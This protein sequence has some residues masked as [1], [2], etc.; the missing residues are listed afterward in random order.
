MPTGEWRSL[1]ASDIG[2]IARNIRITTEDWSKVPDGQKE[3]IWLDVKKKWNI[4]DEERRKT[5]LTYV[6]DRFKGFKTY[7]TS[8]FVYHTK[9]SRRTEAVDPLTIYPQITKEDWDEFVKQR[10]DPE[11]RKKSD[12]ARASQKNNIHPHYMGRAGYT[13]KK[14]QWFKEELEK[15]S[16]ENPD[17]DPIQT[18]ESVE[19]R[20]SDRAY[21]WIK[22]HTPATRSLPPQT[23]KLIDD[24]KHWSEMVEKGE[25]VPSRLED[26]LVKATGKPD[27]PGRTRGVGSH[28]GLQTYFGKPTG[29]GSRGK[30]YS[31]DDMMMFKEEVK[32]ETMAE[33]K[34][35]MQQQFLELMKVCG[36]KL[37]P[38]F[39]LNMTDSPISS[40]HLH[41]SSCH[42]IELRDPFSEL[43]GPTPCRLGVLDF[44]DVV[45]VAEGMAW[46]WTENQTIHN[47][48]LS[49]Q[50][51]RV[52]IDKILEITAPLPIPWGGFK[53]VGEVG[54]SFAQW[55]KSLVMMGL[56]EALSSDKFKSKET[57]ES[58]N[59]A[60][61]VVRKTP[62]KTSKAKSS[63]KFKSKDKESGNKAKS[64]DKFKSKDKEP[65]NKVN[66]EDQEDQEHDSPLS[67]DEI[68]SL[69]EH[70]HHL[71]RVLCSCSLSSISLYSVAIDKSVYNYSENIKVF[72]SIGDIRQMFRYKWLNIS[73]LQ[74]WGSFLHQH[75]ATLK[76]D[77]VVGYLCPERL[78]SYMYDP[79]EMQR[80]IAQ[81]L[82]FQQDKKYVMGAFFE[83]DH[84]MLVVFCVQDNIAYIFDSDQST[85]K[86]LKI[87][88][89]LK[90]SWI[91]YGVQCGK[92][93]PTKKYDLEC[94]IIQCPQQPNSYECGYYV[95][96]WMFDIVVD[97]SKRKDDL[98]KCVQNSVITVEDLDE[99]RELWS[100]HCKENFSS[101]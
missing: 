101:G 45:V 53:K 14:D 33:M 13:G 80:Y 35:V 56:D 72:L 65:G 11:F 17:V 15:E 39:E 32:K 40:Q 63:D 69:K 46:P 37:P 70:C 61:Q 1:F 78:S 87:I 21:A 30:L 6:G 52:S 42:S 68:S 41:Q 49:R 98:E 88:E 29:R 8:Y 82:I 34:V 55:P 2:V 22:A 48:P 57:K 12:K 60:Q 93:H 3:T 89:E 86:E 81:V 44:E 94:K 99:V 19:T 51:I 36:M 50:N 24:I 84:W 47:T 100:K 90:M 96:K 74:V 38:G 97:Y 31:T 67:K 62:K 18:Q 59:K 91:S 64:Y 7:L 77:D 4:K 43:Q 71:E 9:K 54:G 26:V 92:R 27:H 76:V 28:V 5:I 20:L 23:Q 95:M 85:K 25:F 75:G 10:M 79:R 73:V 58:G 66:P 83:R 16:V